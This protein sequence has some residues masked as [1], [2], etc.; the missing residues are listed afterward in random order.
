[1]HLT[2]RLRRIEPYRSSVH[3]NIY[4]K[5][6]VIYFISVLYSFKTLSLKEAENSK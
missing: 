3:K 2:T 6:F 4:E 5:T 1:M